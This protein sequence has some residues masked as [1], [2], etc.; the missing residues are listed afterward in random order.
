M[1]C[2]LASLHRLINDCHTTAAELSFLSNYSVSRAWLDTVAAESFDIPVIYPS[3]FPNF[4]EVQQLYPRLQVL[5]ANDFQQYV[6]MIHERLAYGSVVTAIDRYYLDYITPRR[7]MGAHYIIINDIVGD[8]LS[9][10]DPYDD[11]EHTVSIDDLELWTSPPHRP[12]QYMGYSVAFID[13]SIVPKKSLLTLD[14]VLG[15]RIA[16]IQSTIETIG[17]FK[18]VPSLSSKAQRFF[19]KLALGGM[20]E[21]DFNKMNG[22]LENWEFFTQERMPVS[23]AIEIAIIGYYRVLA[24]VFTWI[25]ARRIEITRRRWVIFVNLYIVGLKIELLRYQ[26]LKAVIHGTRAETNIQQHLEAM[27]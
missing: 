13:T 14:T 4:N 2:Y 7:H 18:R 11:S 25:Y 17:E 19:L 6:S 3:W 23:A 9:Y 22:R 5:H 12:V 20:S 16:N 1:D 26:T 15:Q 10:A 21:S 24:L 8:Y 27:K